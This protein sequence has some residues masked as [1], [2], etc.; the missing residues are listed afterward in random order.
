MDLRV[1]DESTNEFTVGHIEDIVDKGIQPV[2]R[3]TLVDGR[4]VTMTENHRVLTDEGW[5]TM[6][7]AVGLVGEGST[8]RM[9]RHASFITNGVP[10]YQDR[11]I[12]TRAGI[13]ARLSSSTSPCR[14]GAGS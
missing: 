7:E 8:A 14:S 4:A 3:V 1:L 2:Y 6:R 10:A 13:R 11:D 9:T 5:R 12:A